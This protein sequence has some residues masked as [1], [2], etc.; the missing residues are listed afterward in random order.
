[1]AFKEY[2]KETLG[3][4]EAKAAL[5]APYIVRVHNALKNGVTKYS[6]DLGA[7]QGSNL[8]IEKRLQKSDVFMLTALKLGIAKYDPAAPDHNKPVFTYPDPVY[9]T[10][11]IA[12]QLELLY[13]GKLSLKTGSVTRIDQLDCDV[14]KTVPGDGFAGTVAAPTDWPQ[15]GPTDADR[16]YYDLGMYPI[17]AGETQNSFDLDLAPGAVASIADSAG[18]SNN[19]ILFAMGW[20]YKGS[21]PGGGNCQ[22]F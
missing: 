3:E 17:L 1:M 10:A 6:F 13:Q 14:F 22:V 18:A 15:Y 12:A 5:V 11:A 2:L 16:G 21:N 20:I 4:N 7:G 19:A 8:V 9:F